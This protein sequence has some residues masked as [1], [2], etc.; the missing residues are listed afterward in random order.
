MG[1]L[2]RGRPWPMNGRGPSEGLG[3]A[4]HRRW[5][6]W[7][8][9]LPLILLLCAVP[10]QAQE[11]DTL[12]PAKLTVVKEL[13]PTRA[14]ESAR[15]VTPSP[16]SEVIARFTG[17][18]VK[19]YGG[20]GGLKTV[21]VRSLGSEHVGVFLD[22]IRIDNAQNMQVDLGRLSTDGIGQVALYSGVMAGRLQTAGAYASGASL[23]LTSTLTNHERKII[24]QGGTLGTV[25]PSFRAGMRFAEGLNANVS[26]GFLYS[27][28]RYRYPCFD[29]TLVR[30]NGDIRALRLEATLFGGGRSD[31]W[32]LKLYSY[33]SERGFPGP[34]IRRAAGF[35]FSAER[36]ADQDL[37]VQGSWKREWTGLYAT[38]LRFKYANNY[39]H[40]NTHPEK[41]PMAMPY[42][43]HYRQQSGFLSLAQSF[44]PGR[45]WSVDWANDLQRNRLDGDSGGFVKPRRTTFTS[46]LAGRFITPRFRASASAVWM[47]AWDRFDNRTPSGWSRDD[48]FRSAWMP[49]A[50]LFWLPSQRLEIEAFAK[51]SYRLPSFND[52]YYTLMGN[53]ALSPE[54]ALQAGVDFR[55]RG[56]RWSVSLSPYLNRVEDKIVAI[57][58]AS[59]FRWTMLNIGIADILGLDATLLWDGWTFSWN[60]VVT[61]ARWS[62]TANTPD[63]YIAPWSTTDVQLQ[64]TVHLR[65]VDE[66]LVMLDLRNIFSC[67]YEIVQGYPMPGFTASL[68]ASLS[69]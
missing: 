49:S 55:A 53:S 14:V 59:Q 52:L 68:T 1:V 45:H 24:L 7:K 8:H 9:P 15:P 51:R 31:D 64:R 41:N 60:T 23:Q 37:F 47:G 30:E 46:A 2:E 36:Q 16:L 42:D 12:A 34:V 56:A 67:R 43:L 39:T 28:G 26:G 57:P 25:A 4:S 5:R 29:T 44:T 58:T 17:V 22:G 27:A 54:K 35:P 3:G 6:R 18:Q 40:Y 65:G 66:L 20:A 48:A 61:G 62:R 32:Q 50:S 69:W 11:A 10:L 21:N 13:P 33:G 38:A 19:D 63:Y